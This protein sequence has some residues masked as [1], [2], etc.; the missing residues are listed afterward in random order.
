MRELKES[1]EVEEKAL[2]YWN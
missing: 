1:I 2:F